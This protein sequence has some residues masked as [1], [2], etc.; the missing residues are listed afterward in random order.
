MPSTSPSLVSTQKV[1]P[2]HE[3]LFD[4]ALLKQGH[5]TSSHSVAFPPESSLVIT[6]R[7]I[8]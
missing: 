4:I 6:F 5:T 2:G 1:H 8:R 3:L 7:P